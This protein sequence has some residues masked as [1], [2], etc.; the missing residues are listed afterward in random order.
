MADDIRFY[1]FDFNLLC[2][3]PPYL[4]NSGY[5]SINTT[6]EFCGNGAL[7]L[8]YKDSTVDSILEANRDRLI[9]V[10]RDFQGFITSYIKTDDKTTLMGMHL[11]GLLHRVVIP[12]LA[13]TTATAEALVRTAVSENADWFV[14]GDLAGFDATAAHSTSKYMYAD[15]YA[16]ELL[17]AENGGF[18]ITADFVNKQYSFCCLKGI[19]SDLMLSEGNLNAYEFQTTYSN[20]ELAFGGW[21]EKEPTEAEKEA[22]ENAEAIW[23]YISTDSTK[24]GIN[25]IDA[26]L[27]AKTE[28]E[29][30]AELAAKKAEYD[31]TAKTRG[32]SFGVDYRL[33]DIVRV[34]ENGITVRKQITSVDIWQEDYLGE[35]PKL[36]AY[37]EEAV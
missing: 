4:A 6:R 9:L 7:E 36:S 8:V 21:Y 19:N 32:V 24:T 17:Q 2:V 22:D 5:I 3:L 25:K 13:E 29:A 11:N 14:L 37:I 20:K 30:K 1:D 26:V 27:G 33:G 18:E 34:Q 12:P 35:E 16:K 15:E 28:A 23:T 31:I 10:W